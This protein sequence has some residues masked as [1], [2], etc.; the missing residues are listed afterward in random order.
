MDQTL[1]ALVI[2]D[3]PQVRDFVCAVLEADG[4]EVTRADSAEAAFDMLGHGKWKVVFSDI[5]LGGADGFA[6]LRRF[7]ETLPDTKI[8]L[9]TGHGNADG[10]LDAAAYGAYDYLL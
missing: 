1:Q 9:M 2:D 4:W 10:A 6:V 8:V 5:V 3:E 7:K